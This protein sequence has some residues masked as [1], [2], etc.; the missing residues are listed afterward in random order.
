MRLRQGF[1]AGIVV[2]LAVV[3]VVA[4]VRDGDPAPAATT[5]VT[6]AVSSATTATTTATTSSTTTVVA[7]SPSTTVVDRVAEVEAILQDLWFRWFDAIY[8]KDAD[9]LWAVVATQR[10]Y[11]AGVAAMDQEGLFDSRPTLDGTR[12]TIKEIPLDR[13]DCLA[14][15][16]DLDITEYRGEGATTEKLLVLW[17]DERFGWRMAK[18]WGSPNDL[19]R[20]DCDLVT[21]PVLP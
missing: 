5:A 1:A 6:T 21:R 9:A 19:W 20:N 3:A 13:V 10:F 18:A 15:W 17:P 11:D 4:F 16:Y 14:V 12:V 7:V 8:R 2:V